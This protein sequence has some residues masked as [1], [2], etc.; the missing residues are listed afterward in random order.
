MNKFLFKKSNPDHNKRTQSALGTAYKAWQTQGVD[1][2]IIIRKPI[3]EGAFRGYW[4]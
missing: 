2:E 4:L 1:F 3:D